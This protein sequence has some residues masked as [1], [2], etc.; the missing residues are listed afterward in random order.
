MIPARDAAA[1]AAPLTRLLGDAP[2]PQRLG[3][4]ALARVLVGVDSA[5][6]IARAR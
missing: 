3:D 4:G 5:D 1:L 6:R 2:L